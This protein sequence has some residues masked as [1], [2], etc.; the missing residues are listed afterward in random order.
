MK[1][2]YFLRDDGACGYYR[3]DLPFRTY[4][5]NGGISVAKFH[6]GGDIKA[7]EEAVMESDAI[8]IPRLCEKRFIQLAIELQK[9]GVKIIVDHDDNMFKVSPLSPHYH[10][11]GTEE[12]RY[13]W[14]DGK[15]TDIWIDGKKGFDLKKNREKCERFKEALSVA[16]MVT[17]TTP[18]LKNVYDEFSDNVVVLPNCVDTNLWKKLPLKPH[19]GIRMGWFGGHSHYGDWTLLSDVIPKVM[20]K[21]PNLTLVLMGTMFSGTLKGVDPKRIEFHEWVATPAYP[22]KAAILD[23]DFAIIPLE[24]NE[25]NRCKSNIKWVEMGALCTP[26]V[27]SFVSPYREYAT[28]DNGIFIEANNPS[29]WIEGIS[30]LVEDKHLRETMGIEAHKTV[31]EYF[32]INKKWKLWEEAYRKLIGGDNGKTTVGVGEKVCGTQVG[33]CG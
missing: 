18:I 33:A 12:A 31:R 28:E 9:E 25:F 21:Y 2:V 13:K 19:E 30:M 27:T 14:P 15:I 23:L 5:V 8:V 22:Y 7:L 4:A 26:S 1:I 6:Q 32:D 11:C 17:V 24:D 16:D 29:A 3:V 20:N 10:D